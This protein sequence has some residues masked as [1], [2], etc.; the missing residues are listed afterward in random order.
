[1]NQAAIP[2]A[3][4]VGL[5]VVA[6]AQ[7]AQPLPGALTEWGEPA[8]E[9]TWLTANLQGRPFARTDACQH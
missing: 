8:L 7:D 6:A 4:V 2:L 1:V 9:G 5:G 3:L